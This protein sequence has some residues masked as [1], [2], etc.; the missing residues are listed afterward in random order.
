MSYLLKI[1]TLV[2]QIISYRLEVV[3][4]KLQV[5]GYLFNLLHYGG[6]LYSSITGRWETSHI[7]IRV[8]NFQRNE[9]SQSLTHWERSFSGAARA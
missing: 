5:V 8:T 4:Y 6:W 7:I 2:L 3:S 9:C 1:V